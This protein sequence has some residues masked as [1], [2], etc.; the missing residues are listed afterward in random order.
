MT[1]GSTTAAG[2]LGRVFEAL[3]VPLTFRLWDGTAVPVGPRGRSACAVVFRSPRVLRRLLRRPTPLRFGEAFVAGEIDI[4]GDLF[5]A[6][7]AANHVERLRVPL[8][9]R[10]AVLA[11]LWR[12]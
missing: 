9:T 1:R 12:V 11:G 10:L 8:A 5:A 6:V 3:P 4:E 2:L 7:E